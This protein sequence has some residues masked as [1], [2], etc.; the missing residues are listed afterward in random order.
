MSDLTEQVLSPKCSVLLMF[1]W[2][3]SQICKT[4]VTTGFV[5]SVRPAAL[6]LAPIGQIHITSN[7]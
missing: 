2:V 6:A 7:I 1:Y 4:K 5:M 3:R